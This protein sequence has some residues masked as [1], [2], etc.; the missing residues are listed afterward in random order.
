[1]TTISAV[2]G[3]LT[4]P[5]QTKRA[6]S[7]TTSGRGGGLNME[8]YTELHHPGN[9]LE[10]WCEIRVRKDFIPKGGKPVEACRT[11]REAIVMG[12]PSENDKN[13]HCDT[14][15]CGTPEPGDLPTSITQKFLLTC[16]RNS[17]Y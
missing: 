4:N 2:P 6:V 13:H 12:W 14:M 15:G 11:D 3:T 5:I 10:E 8:H 1:M 16:L 7:V 9:D 17:A